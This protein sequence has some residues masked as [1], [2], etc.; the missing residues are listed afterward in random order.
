MHQC[1]RLAQ[2]LLLG[3]APARSTP[4]SAVLAA[5]SAHTQAHHHRATRHGVTR[6]LAHRCPAAGTP[7]PQEPPSTPLLLP[8]GA[9]R[10]QGG[11]SGMVSSYGRPWKTGALSLRSSTMIGSFLETYR[12]SG[13]VWNGC[14]RWC[15]AKLGAVLAPHA[16]SDSKASQ[17]HP[18][19]GKP[20]STPLPHQAS[21]M[22]LL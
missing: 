14:G 15:P 18:P 2:R 9:G 10:S 16:L 17:H 4:R 20:T 8:V 19:L 13:R 5:P 1:L 22:A 11:T 7:M 12:V 3:T 21:S 6:F